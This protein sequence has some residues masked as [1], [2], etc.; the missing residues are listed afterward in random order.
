MG[1]CSASKGN[2][3]SAETAIVTDAGVKGHDA[4]GASLSRSSGSDLQRF[5]RVA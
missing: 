4:K 1:G 5:H 3:A 2:T